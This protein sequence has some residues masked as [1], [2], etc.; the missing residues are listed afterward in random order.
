MFP[1]LFHWKSTALLLTTIISLAIVSAH[2]E[3]TGHQHGMKHDMKHE[4]HSQHQA[5]SIQ[6]EHAHHAHKSGS[7]MF[8]YRYMRMEMDQLLAGSDS[9]AATDVARMGSIYKNSAGG[10]YMM[11]PTDMSMDMHML[12]GMYAQSDNLSWMVMLNYL[13]NNMNMIAMTGARSNMR[14][15]GLGDLELGAMYRVYNQESA[16]LLANLG[17]SLPTGSIT[18]SNAQGMLPYAMQLGSG[19]YDLKPSLTYRDS[20]NQWGWGLQASYTFRSGENSQ[21]YTL[22]NRA[23]GQGWL[24]FNLAKNTSLSGRLTLSDWQGISG[25]DTGITM[26]QRNMSPTFDA[27]NSGGRRLDA[28]IGISHMLSKGHMLGAAYG[29]PLHQNLDGLQMKTKQMFSFSWQFMY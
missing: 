12:M 9:V 8:E 27:L 24:K 11:V 22:G 25:S 13:N 2:A 21:G 28:S 5:S 26:M 1:H 14:A 17:I 23:E 20:H 19:T 4:N 10:T 3:E 16:Q 18:Q 29:I 15:T 6:H 7:W